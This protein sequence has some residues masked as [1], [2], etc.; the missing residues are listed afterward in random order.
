MA[1]KFSSILGPLISDRRGVAA[2]EFALI[3]PL[4]LAMCLVTWELALAIETSRKV[5]RAGSMIG[6]LVTQSPQMSKAELKGI[7]AIS[8]S[9]IQPYNRSDPNITVTAIEITNETTPKTKIVWEY[10]LVGKSDGQNV[11]EAGRAPG[12]LTDVPDKLETA[13]SFL[14]EVSSHLDYV[15]V[16]VWSTDAKQALGLTS[17]RATYNMNETY[18]MRP[19]VTNTIACG[20]C[21]S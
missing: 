17:S 19:R 16:I 11:Y 8:S 12:S 4:M 10:K 21:Y 14:I 3:A 15:P 6:D 1:N 20:D 9:A 13:G 18:Y 7:L 5:G 2:I